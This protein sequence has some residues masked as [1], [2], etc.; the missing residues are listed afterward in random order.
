MIFS[1]TSS[2]FPISSAPSGRGLHSLDEEPQAGQ[3]FGEPDGDPAKRQPPR[4]LRHDQRSET[5]DRNQQ[6]SEQ[7]QRREGLGKIR[8][9]QEEIEEENRPHAEEYGGDIESSNAGSQ[10]QTGDGGQLAGI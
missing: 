8:R 2:G 9:S 6:G 10:T 5:Y 1:A 4:S 3:D 7:T